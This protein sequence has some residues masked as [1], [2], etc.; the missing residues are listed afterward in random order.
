MQL[1]FGPDVDLQALAGLL[2]RVEGVER[3]MA[4]QGALTIDVDRSIEALPRLLQEL[5]RSGSDMRSMTVRPPD[6]ETVFPHL[7]VERLD[8][9]EAG[10]CSGPWRGTGC[11]AA[12]RNLGH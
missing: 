3:V 9:G 12:F 1:E 11:P 6:L 7:T 10:G 5:K 4:V 8:G 2:G